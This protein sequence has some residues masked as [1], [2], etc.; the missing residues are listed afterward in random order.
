[1][2]SPNPSIESL[3]K[4][5][6]EKFRKRF[7]KEA[8]LLAAAPGRVNLIGEHIDYC[9]GFVLPFAIAR[10]VIIAAAPNGTDA[11]QA[12]TDF[13]DEIA[14]FSVL[15]QQAKGSPKWSNYLRGVIHGFHLREMQ[16]PGFDAFIISSLPG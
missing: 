10:T 1:M 2:L 6:G 13:T 15:P 4:T 7:G 11:V 12:A 8:T 3:A 16:V 5:A 9:D 14:A